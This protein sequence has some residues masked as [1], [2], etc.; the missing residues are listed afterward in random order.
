LL[1]VH[2]TQQ[3]TDAQLPPD[4]KLEL[5]GVVSAFSSGSTSLIAYEDTDFTYTEKDEISL[6][7][8]GFEPLDKITQGFIPG[9]LFLF[10]GASGTG[11]TSIML[12]TANNLAQ[13][14]S[15]RVVWVSLEM[16]AQGV[17]FRSRYL[18]LQKNKEN[19]I[20]TSVSF[21]SIKD[22]ADN[23]T[24][25]VV[26][27][28][29]LMLGNAQDERLAIS[30]IYSALTGLSKK[31]FML[32][33]ASQINRTSDSISLNS[34]M[35]SGAKGFYPEM[36]IALYRGGK[37]LRH[38]GYDNVTL[39]CIK[40]RFGVSDVRCNFPFN[41]ATLDYLDIETEEAQMYV[42]IDELFNG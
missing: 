11:K 12:R 40:H 5:Y 24:I 8:F 30:N 26:D 17:K 25:L 33:V 28:P 38:P 39:H 42:D 29:D 32:I 4:K 13:L 34:L 2:I 18:N 20:L 31:C 22:Y 41:Y 23:N 35:G 36:I 21:E 3:I 7:E 27:Y 16:T 14:H 15:K 1:S 9:T 6:L 10:S 19:R 37:N